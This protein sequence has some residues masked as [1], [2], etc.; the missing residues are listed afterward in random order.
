MSAPCRLDDLMSGAT[1]I[2]DGAL[3]ITG[4]SA[5]SRSIR[6]GY[7]FAA[8]AGTQADGARYLDDA[9]AKGAVAVLAAPG[10]VAA[11]PGLAIVMDP[12]PR[13][14][15]ALAAARFHPRQPA[16]VVAV[17]GTNGKTSV[18][19]FTRQLWEIL[20]QQAGA[21]G[22]LGVSATGYEMPLG[23]TTPDPVVLHQVLDDLATRG[24]SC[25]AMEA[26]SHGIDQRRLDGVRLAAAALTNVTRDHLDYHGTV[27]AYWQAKRRL[28]ADLLPAGATVVVE[29]RSDHADELVALARVRGLGLVTVGTPEADL[30]LLGQTPNATGQRLH[31]GWKGRTQTVNL[32]LAGAFQASNALVALG[33]V[34]ATGGDATGAI[35]AMEKLEGV[36]GRMERAALH[37]CGAPVYVDYA[38][39]PDALM[40]I[41]SA[42]RP[43][44]D[45]RLIVVFGAGGDRDAGK[46]PEMGAVANRLA[47]MVIVTDDN[48]RSEE[49]AAIRRA[50]LAAAP[51]ATEIGDRSAAIRTAVSSLETGDVLVIAGKGHEQGQSAG[52]VTRPFDDRDEARAAVALIMEG[53]A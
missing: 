23:M 53:R 7:L 31:I 6:P 29:A 5:D 1:I 47:D 11:R 28:F 12:D 8:L 24:I 45:R 25:V 17:T 13:R 33:L 44:T 52:G 48:P 15:L 35:A 50:I 3:A 20:G 36:P 27:E 38:H 18:A 14:R 51:G 2:G 42:L 22:T 49:P 41:L 43:H 39:T 32:P 10:A 30:A 37:P 26:S 4:L 40:T 9:L 16:T 21:I 46:R 34:L 19:Q